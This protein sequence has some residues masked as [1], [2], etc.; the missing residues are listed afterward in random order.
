MDHLGGVGFF[1]KAAEAGSFAAAA[2]GLGVTPS[3]VSK[4]VSRLEDR[5]GVQLFRRSTRSIDLTDDGRAFFERARTGL[6][7]IEAAEA[8]LLER[9]AEPIGRLRV[10]APVVFAHRIVAPLLPDF[11]ERYPKLEVEMHSTDGL[12]DLIEDGFDVL[13]RT[14][15]LPDSALIGEYVAKRRLV[16]GHLV[17][18][19][20]TIVIAGGPIDTTFLH[21]RLE[22]E[23]LDGTREVELLA[24]KDEWNCRT[25]A[26]F[27]G[28]PLRQFEEFLASVAGGESFTFDPESDVPGQAIAPRRVS[29][30]P[31]SLRRQRVTHNS[32]RFDIRMR[33]LEAPSV[34]YVRDTFTAPNGTPINGAYEPDFIPVGTFQGWAKRTP[35]GGGVQG[36]IEIQGNEVFITQDEQ[37]AIINST[38]SDNFEV[39]MSVRFPTAGAYR[40]GLIARLSVSGTQVLLRWQTSEQLLEIVEYVGGTPTVRGTAAFT[41]TTPGRHTFAVQVRGNDYV[42]FIDG[43]QVVTGTSTLNTP[44]LFHGFTNLVTVRDEAFDD[45]FIRS[46]AS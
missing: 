31:S 33:E 2:K 10:S 41:Y 44:N 28:L 37:G 8:F 27:T 12:S 24:L 22:N 1:V 13:I 46:L 5:L 7:E 36:A 34:V 6:S 11:C 38:I 4:A 39:Q 23:S 42:G 14:R 21:D 15:A 32:F 16:P 17:D 30:L 40:G 45:F 20:Y 19:P 18:E 25:D 3:A 35:D 26:I 43:A 29:L 9:R